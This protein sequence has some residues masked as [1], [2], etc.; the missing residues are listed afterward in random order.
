LATGKAWVNGQ[1]QFPAMTCEIG[2]QMDR[3]LIRQ[4]SKAEAEEMMSLL[5]A[6]DFGK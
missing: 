1:R 4:N 2:Y 5:L 6:G 3:E